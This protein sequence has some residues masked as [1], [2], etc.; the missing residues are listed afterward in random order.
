MHDQ[1]DESERRRRKGREREKGK[2]RKNKRDRE[3]D[4]ERVDSSIRAYVL[5]AEQS[6]VRCK[7]YCQ[8]YG[9]NSRVE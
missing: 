1:E 7:P 5:G 6:L 8:I 9:R 3:R 4:R 2:E